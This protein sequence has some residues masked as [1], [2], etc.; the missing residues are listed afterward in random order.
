MAE[1]FPPTVQQISQ[2]WLDIDDMKE[3][4]AGIVMLA[5]ACYGEEGEPTIRAGEVAAAVQ[6]LEWALERAGLKKAGS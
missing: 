3:R 2:V 4:V 5:Q 6:R 1:H